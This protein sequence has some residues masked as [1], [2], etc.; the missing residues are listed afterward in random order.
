MTHQDDVRKQHLAAQ[1]FSGVTDQPRS[2]A[3]RGHLGT[4]RISR[5]PV[6]TNANATGI[7]SIDDRSH[8]LESSTSLGAGKTNM[9]LLCGI[10]S[11]VGYGN[12]E[13]QADSE[14]HTLLSSLDMVSIHDNST[15]RLQESNDPRLP[16]PTSD[17]SLGYQAD[18]RLSSDAGPGY[19]SDPRLSSDAGLGYQT[20]PLLSITTSDADPGYQAMEKVGHLGCLLFTS[21]NQS[22]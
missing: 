6:K 10:G 2:S 13:K 18:P 17:T 16:V 1:L 12:G 11:A 4:S 8:S 20:D 14:K 9:D 19:P 22:G 5:N 3:G 15:P 7:P 21:S